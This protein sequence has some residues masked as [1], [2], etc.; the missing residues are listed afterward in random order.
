MPDTLPGQNVT[1]LLFGDV[2]IT[3]A[4]SSTDTALK[5]MQAFYLRTGIGDARCQQAP[6]SGLLVQTPEGVGIVAFNVNGV[7]VAMGSTVFF[8]ANIER[9]TIVR[10]LEGAAFVETEEGSQ[11]ILAGTQVSVPMG[12][13]FLPD[14]P[15][16]PP[17]SYEGDETM[18]LSLPLD[19]LQREIDVAPPLTDAEL[20]S[21]L[22]RIEADEPLCGEPPF[23]E[24]DRYPFL[25]DHEDCLLPGGPL[26]GSAVEPPPAELS[27][28]VTGEDA[29]TAPTGDNAGD[30]VGDSGGNDSGDDGG[31]EG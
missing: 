3:N 26:C 30:A 7:D 1:F 22:S 20:T 5:P 17:S 9:G 21:L 13:D 25:A 24:C 10:T 2:D 31:G 6:D 12:E 8:Q 23:P 29:G 27:S 28:D 14:G 18:L 11:P 19:L 15:P 16:A 4:V